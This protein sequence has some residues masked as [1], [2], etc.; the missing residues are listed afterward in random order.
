MIKAEIKSRIAQ[1]QRGELPKGYQ[2]SHL[3]IVP[4]GWKIKRLGEITQKTSR[5][6]RNDR[7]YPACSI[8][9]QI[10]FILQSKQFEQGSYDFLDKTSYKIVEKDEFAYNPARINVGS[11]GRLKNMDKV[12]VSSLYVCFKL[13]DKNDATYFENWFNGYDFYKEII[14]NLEG[15]VREYLFYKNF[16]R[17]QMPVPPIA[18]QQKIAEILAQCDKVIALKQELLD[19]KRKQKKWLMQNL[20]N[21]DSGVRLPKFKGK[22]W[23]NYTM[24]ELGEFSKGYGISNE[25]CLTGK[26]PCI[27]YGD[28]YMFFDTWF[29][30]PVSFTEAEIAEDSPIIS[31]GTLL[32]TGSGEDRLEIGKCTVYTGSFPIAVGGDIIIMEPNENK[33]DPLFLVYMQYTEGLIRQKAELCQGYSIVHIYASDIKKLIVSIPSTLEEQKAIIKTI[34]SADRVITLLEQELAA[35]HEKKKGLAQLL[36]TGLVRV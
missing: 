24:S 7:S 4:E 32:F 33:V 36:L 16:S 25:D 34:S 3:Y 9:N 2:H 23:N 5:K 31:Q 26:I 15:S 13:S 14:R 1:V 11:I 6:N 8:N 12:I 35:W 20:L 27:K 19:E 18:E 21:P 29:N 30:T 17:I 10:G 22:K 28:I